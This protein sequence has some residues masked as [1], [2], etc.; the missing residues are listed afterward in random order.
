[1]LGETRVRGAHLEYRGMLTH[2][3][4]KPPGVDMHFVARNLRSVLAHSRAREIATGD[5][6]LTAHLAGP[7]IDVHITGKVRDLEVPIAGITLTR[8]SAS[9]R[10]ARKTWT[11][12]EMSADVAGGNV[13][14]SG[15]VDDV[16]W[17]AAMDLRDIDRTKL[18]GLRSVEVL[19]YLSSVP[20]GLVR[21]G[22]PEVVT[23]L[24]LRDI[25]ITLKRRSNERV[26]F[27]MDLAGKH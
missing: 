2:T 13:A 21:P 7:F 23:H 9:Y 15:N 4:S 5:A 27:H 25:D 8:V 1:M 17:G 24:R 10:H 6:S 20:G 3:Y 12:E 19:A 11:V 26:P 16:R 14:G 22:S 18:G